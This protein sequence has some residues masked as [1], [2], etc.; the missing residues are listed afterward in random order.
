MKTAHESIE[1]TM[2][3]MTVTGTPDETVLQ[4]ARRYDIYIPTLC[5]HD[6]LEPY[7]GC[8]LCLVEITGFRALTTACTTKIAPGM[9]VRTESPQ[10]EKV[11]R[12]NLELILAEHPME[13]LTCAQNQQCELQS[14]AAYLGVDKVRYRSLREHLPLEESNPFFTYDPNKCVLCNRCVRTC[15]SRQGVGGI[16]LVGRGAATVVGTANRVPLIESNCESC[17]ECVVHCP[18]GALANRQHKPAV[19]KV[20]T[21]CTFCGTGCGML[22]GV[23]GGKIVSTEGERENPVN[24]GRLCVKGRYGNDFVNSPNRLT[25][26]LIKRDGKFEEATWD[27]ALDLVVSKFKQYA[28]GEFAIQGSSRC[29]N[30]DNYVVQKFSRAVMGTNNVDNC[31]RLCHAPTVSGLAKAFGTGGGT[32]PLAELADTECIFV[33]GSNTTEAH[34]VVGAQV[35]EAAKRAKL[36][37]A[38]PRRIP[39]VK[40]A[41]LWLQ[42]RPGTDVP[43]LMGIARVIIEEEMHDLEFIAARCE[44]FESFVESLKV[45]DLD[46]V[47]EITGVP[48]EQIVQ[49]AR[50]YGGSKQSLIMYSLGITEHSHGTDNVLAIANLAMLTGNIGRPSA[51]VMPLR[52]QNNVQGA[53]DMGVIPNAFQGY[54]YVN[55]PEVR[56][57]FTAAWGA[58]MPEEPGLT[59]VEQFKATLE[60]K[61]KAYYIIGIDPAY[62][63]TD[64]HKVHEALLKADF[65]VVQDIFLSGTAKFADVILPGTS[66]AEKD[67]TFTNLERRFQR[68]RKAIEPIGDSRPD[69]WITCEIARRM[70]AKGFDFNDPSEIMDEFARLT[71]NFAGL[72]FARLEEAGIQWPCFSADHPGTPRLHVEKFNTPTGEGHFSPLEYRPSAECPDN[73]YPFLLSTGRSLYHFHLAMTSNVEGLMEIQPEE[74]IR[75]HPRDAKRLDVKD[76]EVVKVSSRHGQLHVKALITDIVKPGIAWMTFHFYDVPTNVLTQQDVLDPVS[77]T[78]EFKVTAVRIEKAAV[79]AVP[80]LITEEAVE[81]LVG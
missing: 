74:K 69:W 31:A 13:C 20:R 18:T 29:T 47:A 24:H 30:E 76:G 5:Y 12:L 27:E 59:M 40:H 17:G 11:R 63:V 2:D 46:T 78:P 32:N 28:P 36:I 73:E 55:K 43:L 80:G 67:G 42:H 48:G 77:K 53:C 49:A 34:P 8:R 23:R 60:G 25:T 15:H 16:D 50:M 6:D 66:F 51:G 35:R 65:I 1:F 61:V 39:L 4:V 57:K 45:F 56:E 26:P 19:R 7:G 52:G 41:D 14:A 21:T 64:T 10:L 79:G 75:I 3:G 9:E 72:S 44:N 33:V 22:L 38:D 62:S 54:Q 71:P 70:G 37:V 68:V 81:V 58:P